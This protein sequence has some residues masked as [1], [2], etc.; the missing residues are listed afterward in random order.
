VPGLVVAVAVLCAC[1][2][3]ADWAW[4]GAPAYPF[5]GTPAMVLI[6]V[7]LGIT[8]MAVVARYV[9]LR[10]LV[11]RSAWVW[12]V[13]A[14]AWAYDVLVV[15]M[16]GPWVA[17]VTTMVPPGVPRQALADAFLLSWALLVERGREGGSHGLLACLLALLAGWGVSLCLLGATQATLVGL[18]GCLALAVL[19]RGSYFGRGCSGVPLALAALGMALAVAGV[20]AAD[21]PRFSAYLTCGNTDPFGFGWVYRQ[22]ARLFSESYLLGPAG[23][24]GPYPS[25]VLRAP[26]RWWNYPV[27]GVAVSLGLLP[28]ALTAAC[29]LSLSLVLLRL[30][31]GR[32]GVGQGGA[33]RVALALSLAVQLLLCVL[34]GFNLVPSVGLSMPFSG[35][36]A[37]VS[38]VHCLMVGLVIASVR[39]GRDDVGQE[40]GPEPGSPSGGAPVREVPPGR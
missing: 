5:P 4:G 10:D 12:C 13:T 39:P 28:A 31:G 27:A 36:D 18:G 32:A 17:H 35:E 29:A 16:L 21:A 30:S 11:A 37:M 33:V 15:R 26:L 20:V 23:V 9:R 7:V 22:V 25:L 1:G 14:L 6:R 8:L 19:V 2:Q 40:G 3:V 24:A 34:M 38:W